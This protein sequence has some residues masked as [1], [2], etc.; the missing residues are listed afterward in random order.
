MT[1]FTKADLNVV[2]P[3][4]DSQRKKM[5]LS[6]QAIADAV[7]VSQ[8]TIQRL[9]TRKSSPTYELL[10]RVAAA[11]KYEPTEEPLF[12]TGYTLEDYTEYLKR[13]MIKQAGDYER[14]LLQQEMLF[15]RM[16]RLNR[17]AIKWLSI[18]L[19]VLVAVFILW[20]I[21]DMSHPSHGWL[22]Y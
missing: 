11:I 8:S 20:L 19:G 17:R 22:Q 13:Q 2:I 4:M 16:V 6:Y 10:Q 21:I 15:N 5:K 7:G 3:D 12:P 9:F 18:C 14:Q 1:D